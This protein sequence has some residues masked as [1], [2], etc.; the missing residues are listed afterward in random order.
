MI[1][2]RDEARNMIHET[3]AARPDWVYRAFGLV[4]ELK[5]EGKDLVGMCPFHQERSPSFHITAKGEFAGRCKCWGG[6]CGFGGD[7]LAFLMR[8]KALSF[9]EALDFGAAALGI[10]CPP[11]HEARVPSSP[12]APSAFRGLRGQPPSRETV[13]LLH[14][15]LLARPEKVKWAADKRAWSESI[16]C[17]ARIG[18]YEDAKERRFAVPVWNGEADPAD[19]RLYRPGATE[20]KCIGWAEGTGAPRLYGLRLL[21]EGKPAGE[22]FVTAG[23][24]DCLA[25]NSLGF[26]AITNTAGEG[27]WPSG[28]SLDLAG[29]TVNIVEDNDPAGRKRTPVVAEWA[30]GNGAAGVHRVRVCERGAVKGFDATDLLLEAGG[31]LDPAGAAEAFARWLEVREPVAPRKRIWTT[32]ELLNANFPEPRFLVERVIPEGLVAFGGRPKIGKSWLALQIAKAL[33]EGTET[34]GQRTTRTKVL[35]LA[36]ED[37]SRRLKSRL[38]AQGWNAQGE[39]ATVVVQ[40]RKDEVEALLDEDEYGCLVVDTVSRYVGVADPNDQ[41]LMM[42]AFAELQELALV[43]DLTVLGIDHHLKSMTGDPVHDLLGSTS[44]AAV[45]DCIIG[46]YRERGQ[47]NA[48]LKVVGRDI[49][50]H[51]LALSFDGASC[52]WELHA[53]GGPEMQREHAP[54]VLAELAKRPGHVSDLERRTGINRGTLQRTLGDLCSGG[55]VTAEEQGQRVVYHLLPPDRER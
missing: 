42:E 37:G 10:A 34:L 19:I 46:L 29:V 41:A 6:G 1:E 26:P 5:A 40:P 2:S 52:T 44:K 14:A 45:C 51:E 39:V 7:A 33:T 15:E 22:L 25:L 3:A 31:L 48:A 27:N 8:A 4:G 9:P 36:F 23:E 28:A 12:S 17:A 47:R 30:H 53:E 49:E 18:W 38:R 50:E 32:A 54:T 43:R 35:Y 11:L 55:R 13:E 24:P 16:I 21:P 20:R